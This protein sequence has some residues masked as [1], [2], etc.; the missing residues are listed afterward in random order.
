VVAGGRLSR[1]GK[2][3]QGQAG[4]LHLTDGD[5]TQCRSELAIY[6]PMIYTAQ[7]IMF[8]MFAYPLRGLVGGG[9]ALE[10]ESF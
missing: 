1:G 9:W 6:A 2:E 5:S 10:I 3:V 7:C 8:W 4:H